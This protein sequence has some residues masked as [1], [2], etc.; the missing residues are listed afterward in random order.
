[1]NAVLTKR[2]MLSTSSLALNAATKRTTAFERPASN[3]VE[4][5]KTA[6]RVAKRP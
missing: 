6:V 2:E 3:S 4:K 1:V 5:T